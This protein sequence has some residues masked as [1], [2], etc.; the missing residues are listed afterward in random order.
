MPPPVPHWNAGS[1]CRATPSCTSTRVCSRG[2]PEDPLVQKT[3][4]LPRVVLFRMAAQIAAGLDFLHQKSYIYR[5][6]KADNVLLWSMRANNLVNCKVADLGLVIEAAPSGAK[7]HCGTAGFMAPEVVSSEHPAY[8]Q[9]VDTFSFGM[10]L[11]QMVARR[12]PYDFHNSKGPNKELINFAVEKGQLPMLHDVKVAKFGVPYLAMIMK[13]C[14]SYQP[15]DR[16]TMSHILPLLC[17]PLVQ[18]TIGAH[19]LRSQHSMREACYRRHRHDHSPLQPVTCKDMLETIPPTE[20]WVCCDSHKGAELQVFSGENFEHL[21]TLQIGD[22]WQVNCMSFH[23]DFLWVASRGDKESRIDVFN[24]RSKSYTH[25]IPMLDCSPCC[26]SANDQNI[27]IGTL[28]GCVFVLT[29]DAHC[30][31][32]S[33]QTWQKLTE[34]DISGLQVVG[35]DLWVSY[36]ISISF[37]DCHTLEEKG[38]V[39]PH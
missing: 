26:M 14:L 12:P 31:L 8:D 39:S 35:R 5:D 9:S 38:N 22:K 13:Q 21:H 27:F 17:N 30:E 11:Y 3:A 7:S 19:W 2:N 23:N 6:L 10:V 15:K 25:S 28:E 34:L 24:A 4:P 20:F 37:H 16:P 32:G 1:D 36:G 18:L 33:R 29:D